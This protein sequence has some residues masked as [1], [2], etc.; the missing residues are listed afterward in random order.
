M[1]LIPA[2]HKATTVPAIRRHTHL[3]RTTTARP[4]R[5]DMRRTRATSGRTMAERTAERRMSQRGVHHCRVTRYRTILADIKLT[6]PAYLR[7]RNR[8]RLSCPSADPLRD[9]LEPA[10]MMLGQRL[11]TCN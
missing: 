9:V 7:G 11:A 8:V 6:G 1:A 10:W 5:R 4:I 3:A 2:T